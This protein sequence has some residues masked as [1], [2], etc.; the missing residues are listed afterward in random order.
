MFLSI[1]YTELKG[2][3]LDFCITLYLTIQYLIGTITVQ[4]HQYDHI[5]HVYHWL[6]ITV[7]ICHALCCKPLLNC[8]HNDV[9]VM[10]DTSIVTVF[11]LFKTW[12]VVMVTPIYMI[13]MTDLHKLII[14]FLNDT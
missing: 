13:L 1:H 7:I 5:Y 12:L 9:I 4:R 8:P 6:R 10:L 2:F 11:G 14:S 3:T